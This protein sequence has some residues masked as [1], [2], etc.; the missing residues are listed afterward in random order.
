MNYKNKNK[1]SFKLFKDKLNNKNL[2]KIIIGPKSPNRVEIDNINFTKNNIMYDTKKIINN[3]ITANTRKN[4]H[5]IDF[6][7]HFKVLFSIEII[8]VK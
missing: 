7:N 4:K 8:E 3:K 2:H 1:K 5:I 6:Y